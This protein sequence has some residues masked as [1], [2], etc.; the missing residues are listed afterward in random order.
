MESLSETRPLV[1]AVWSLFSRE[2]RLEARANEPSEVSDRA[3]RALAQGDANAALGLSSRALAEAFKGGDV[4]RILDA[5]FVELQAQL[6]QGSSAQAERTLSL[7]AATASATHTSR[8]AEARAWWLLSVGF[9]G[10]GHFDQAVLRFQE[11]IGGYEIAGQTER[12]AHCLLGRA[13]AEA[14]RGDYVQSL[15]TVAH[16]VR[17]CQ[18]EGVDGTPHRLALQCALA[19]K[20]IGY[21]K[22]ALEALPE[23]VQ[24]CEEVRDEAARCEALTGYADV[25]A[26]RAE[27]DPVRGL[28]AVDALK[29]A[30]AVSERLGLVASELV[31]RTIL[32]DVYRRLGQGEAAQR[33]SLALERRAAFLPGEFALRLARREQEE[34]ALFINKLKRQVRQLRFSLGS[35]ED[36]IL[37]FDTH[38]TSAGEVTDFWCE[39][40]NDAA[41][42]LLR[43]AGGVFVL[44]ALS[45]HPVLRGVESMLRECC[46]NGTTQADEVRVEIRG[47][48]RHLSRRVVPLD[49]GAALC[50]RDVTDRAVWER[51]VQE[52]MRETA[53]ESVRL[54]ARTEELEALNQKLDRL[55]F[56]DGLTGALNHR[57]FHERLNDELDRANRTGSRFSIAMVDVDHFKWLNDDFGHK[58]GDRALRTVAD[59]LAGVCEPSDAVARYG[60]EEFAIILPNKGQAEAM[61]LAERL[62]EAVASKEIERQTVTVSIGVATFVAY[63]SSE[64]TLIEDAD[65][66]LY[67]SKRNGRNRVTHVSQIP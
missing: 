62:R 15:E 46:V 14:R 38:V 53:E 52:A 8:L 6:L 7:I 36:A 66:A 1:E 63:S 56:T 44:S 24:W 30:V 22:F 45:W 55:A 39:T 23:I 42:G 19:G 41:N 31:S 58:V 27:S 35:S 64:E 59:R 34:H 16:A 26:Y 61:A 10:S 5:L 25:L 17:Y 18:A 9:W 54:I 65:R 49:P 50:V 37:I 57:A 29:E 48:L 11:A 4:D 21:E 60:G 33:E 20:D 40:A 43:S 51:Q 13:R 3:K 2:S 12:V 32:C 67:F 28:A 47:Q